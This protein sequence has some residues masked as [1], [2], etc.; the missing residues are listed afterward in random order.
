MSGTTK[1]TPRQP[2]YSR[3]VPGSLLPARSSLSSSAVSSPYL[4]S[5]RT[6]ASSRASSTTSQPRRNVR[7]ADSGELSRKPRREGVY[8]MEPIVDPGCIAFGTRRY[9]AH[10]KDIPYNL[11]WL[12][13]CSDMP[14]TIHGRPIDRPDGCY[15]D[16]QDRV[17]GNWSV[18]FKEPS[19]VPYWE[20]ITRMGCAPGKR[21][22][23]RYQGRLAGLKAD[24]D[25]EN[26]CATT[27]ATVFEQDFVSPTTC[28]NQGFFGMFGIWDIPTTR[29]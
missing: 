17:W 7:C 8:W 27:P 16:D 1:G 4:L 11:P 19:C 5:A 26:M 9:R 3:S 25:W 29:C 15:R 10:L 12:E 28:D 18:T 2:L 14:I 20:H 24:D 22:I 21:G 23:V 13:V 6:S